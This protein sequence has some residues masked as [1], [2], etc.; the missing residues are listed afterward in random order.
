MAHPD[1]TY[2]S[3][4]S[5]P[6]S[7][8][9]APTG[10]TNAKMTEQASPADFGAAIGQ[11]VSKVGE[12]AANLT[13]EYGGMVNATLANDAESNLAQKIG[14]IKGDFMSK[15]GLDAYNSYGAYQAAIEQ[16]Y[17][18]NKA[19]LTLGAGQAYMTQS[20]R[21]VDNHLA[22]GGSYA[23]T[24][25][26]EAHR[27]SYSNIANTD[28]QALLDPNTAADPQRSQYHLDSLKYVAQ[29][30]MDADHPGL[31]TDPKTGEVGF[32]ESTPAGQSLKANYQQ[33][34]DTYL[35]QGYVN[36]YDTL[37]KSDV[38]GAYSAYQK[39]R[40]NIPKA[41]QVALDASFAPRLMD[42]HTQIAN[43]N[44]LGDASR[45]HFD[46]LTD[47]SKSA[48][49][50]TMQHE[51][52]YVSND[53][54]K[55]PTNFGINQESNP[56]VDVSSLTQD[57][58]AKIM[59]DKYWNG[60][61]ADKMNPQMGAVAFDTAVNMGVDK[62]KNLVSQANGDPQKLIDLRRAEY[63]RLAT[64]N[65]DKYGQYLPAWNKRLDDLQ[66]A[67]EGKKTYATNENGAPLSLPDYYRLHSVDIL[68]KGDAYAEQQMPGDLALKRA[69]RESLSNAMQ[70]AIS[71]QS[72]Q[73][74][75]DNKNVMKA[76]N[77]DLTKGNPPSTEAELRAIPGVSSLL[78]RVATQDPKFSE[79]VPTL[80][81]K[82][83]RRN[84]VTNSPNGY[85]T[86]TRVLQ[87]QDDDHPNHIK[88]QNQL[89][90][91]LG[92]TDG[93][94]INAKD[95]NDAKPATE[96]PTEIKEPLLK[97]MQEIASANGNVDGKGE[98]R[99][100]QWYNQAMTVYKRNE[101]LGDKK[102]TD[103]EKILPPAPMPSRIGQ[104]S[105]IVANRVKEQEAPVFTSPD[106][107]EFQ[108]LPPGSPFKDADGKMWTKK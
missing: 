45:D 64:E 91:L 82:V 78:D 84:D 89:D 56:G 51:G 15:T 58:A 33:R 75:M 28:M 70:K 59:H 24:Q 76:I 25:L 68:A 71:N 92:K 38:F 60:I 20:R 32:D 106:D 52:G 107:I 27:D 50:W 69:V 95:Y 42:A 36:R 26:K 18:D 7:P 63:Q 12:V 43:G 85:D 5:V 88:N 66:V 77:G 48:I 100:V 97:H 81:G 39:D 105:S 93:T 102:E 96:L 4:G 17:H 83:A 31:K 86:I 40:D 67:T 79:T 74:M 108:K 13:N 11:G 87:P 14:K 30:Q 73:Y 29:A 94:G 57:Q 103:I 72:A 16:A 3:Q 34:L 21:M 98:Q 1:N 6:F 19:G 104:L 10:A 35:A 101:A 23:A 22:D 61:G 54:G 46:A 65:P 49:S 99:A 8:S 90:S 9:V 53:S 44:T 80:I 62:A 37:A 55:G 2:G 41:G 47:P